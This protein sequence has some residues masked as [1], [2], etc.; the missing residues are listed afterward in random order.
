MT[1][2]NIA[3]LEKAL[4]AWGGKYQNELYKGAKHGWTVPMR[5]VYNHELAEKAFS[6]LIDLFKR[7]LP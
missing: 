7:N 3:D 2:E 5:H 1:E 4:F 6:K